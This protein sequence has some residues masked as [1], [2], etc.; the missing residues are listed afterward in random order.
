MLFRIGMENENEGYRSLA[1]ALEHPG[2]F[3][4]GADADQALAALPPIL[5]EYAE[6]IGRH[7]AAW[8]DPH[9]PELLVEETFQDYDINDDF[10]IV[11][12]GSYAV[13]PFF[14]YDW[15][16]LTA[17]DLET[18]LKILAWSRTD[19]LD[20]LLSLTPEQWSFQGEGERWDVAGIVRHIGGAEWWY[21]DRLGLAFPK[22]EV[23]GEPLERLEKVR[24]FLLGVLPTLQESRQV[25][26]MDGEIWSPRKVLRRTAWH[27]RDHIHH[28]RKVLGLTV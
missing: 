7:E 16:P 20:L 2:C 3:A 26:G 22:E 15:K 27:E 28:I 24:A 25:T 17:D 21:L 19:L 18:G 10:E 11:D 1:W 4:Y 9:D 8:L 5:L 14:Q 13:E 12:K 23:P 6:W